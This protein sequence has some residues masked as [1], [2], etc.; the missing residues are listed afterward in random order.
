MERLQVEGAVG[1]ARKTG[2][3]AHLGDG[4][5]DAAPPTL[6]DKMSREERKRE[7]SRPVPKLATRIAPA[8]LWTEERFVLPPTT[9]MG[10]ALNQPD[11]GYAGVSQEGQ[12]SARA[13][14]GSLA[15]SGAAACARNG[16][17][18]LFEAPLFYVTGNGRPVIVELESH[19]TVSY[20]KVVA[21]SFGTS[22]WGEIRVQASLNVDR[23]AGYV[24]EGYTLVEGFSPRG[25]WENG[26][27]G[28]WTPS[29]PSPRTCN[30]LRLKLDIPDGATVWLDIYQA[31]V[32]RATRHNRVDR[33]NALVDLSY[34]VE[35]FVVTVRKRFLP[36]RPRG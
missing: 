31:L 33:C 29:N 34:S 9:F 8:F 15:L 19:G 27:V 5:D 14:A 26:F 7:R 28:T 20:D 22:S 35:P 17:F 16:C 21:D 2:R 12:T 18:L 3:S 10:S 13:F 6:V 32:L 1:P 11:G 23:Y 25:A 30:R 4:R 36:I 24:Y